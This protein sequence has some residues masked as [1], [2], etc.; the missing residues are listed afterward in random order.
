MGFLASLFIF[1]NYTEMGFWR[2]SARISRKDKITNN[3]IK[4]KMKVTRSLLDDVKTASMVRTVQ[5]LEGGRLPKGVLE[6]RPSG[7]RKRG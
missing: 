1:F 5:R 7:R 3:V 2:R 6:W 4:K